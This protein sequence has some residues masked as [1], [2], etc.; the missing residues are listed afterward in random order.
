MIQHSKGEKC[1]KDDCE[2]CSEISLKQSDVD[3][4]KIYE[5]IST[6]VNNIYEEAMMKLQVI[7]R[8]NIK[9]NNVFDEMY[10]E[11]NDLENNNLDVMIFISIATISFY[12]LCLLMNK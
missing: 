3:L 10:M 12:F 8:K 6:N 2:N 5:K 1:G 7:F 4:E 9:L 11:P